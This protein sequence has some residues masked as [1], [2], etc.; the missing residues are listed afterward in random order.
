MGH[1]AYGNVEGQWSKGISLPN[2]IVSKDFIHLDT[3][4]IEKG[5]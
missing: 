3:R 4:C 1:R 2:E 5:D